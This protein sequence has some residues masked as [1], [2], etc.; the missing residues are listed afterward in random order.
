MLESKPTTA[1]ITIEYNGLTRSFNCKK[2]EYKIEHSYIGSDKELIL[3]EKEILITGIVE[4]ALYS[5]NVQKEQEKH[6]KDDR[7]D[8][9]DFK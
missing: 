8:L 3:G 1:K 9:L 2:F 7:F 4:E 5:M 6:N